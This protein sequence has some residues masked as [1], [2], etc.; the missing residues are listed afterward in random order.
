MPNVRLKGLEKSVKRL[1]GG[2]QVTYWYAWRGGPRLPGHPGEPSFMAAYNAAV[3]DRRTPKAE[4]LA[5][6][7]GR[8][9][10]SPEYA[11][12]ADATR[13]EWGAWLDRIAADVGPK[14]I[15]GLICSTTAGSRQISSTGATN[16][17]PL[18]ARPT[19]R[20]KSCVGP[21]LSASPAAGRVF[22]PRKSPT[23]WVGPRIGSSGFWRPTSTRKRSYWPWLAASSR[24]KSVRNSPENLRK[25]ENR[26]G[27]IVLS[28]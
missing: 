17:A 25:I 26:L 27:S 11:A 9:R 22:Q 18:C 4:T 23:C 1:K 7:V 10:A 21:W 5:G 20:S 2:R 3:A 8:Y 6:L 13:K 28:D 15:G 24:T 12:L 14:D 16:G 19:M